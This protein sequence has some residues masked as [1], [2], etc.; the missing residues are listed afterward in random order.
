MG[1]N[2]NVTNKRLRSGYTTGTCAAAVAKACV[3]M[4]LSK[5]KQHEILV[6]TPQGQIFTLPLYEVDLGLDCA[7][8]AVRKD[9]GDDPDV[10][11]GILIYATVRNATHHEIKIDGGIGIGR[12]TKPG[13]ACSIG[14]AAINPVPRKMIVLEVEKVRE[15]YSSLQGFDI[16]IWAPKGEE[17]ASRTFNPRLGII[18][19]ISILGT[20]GI[21]EPKSLQAL[22]DTIYLEMK[23]QRALGSKNLLLCSGNYG[24]TF[25]RD[26][27]RLDQEQAVLCSNFIGEALDFSV[28]LEF[29][30]ILLVGHAG[31]LLKLGA[32][33]MNTHSKFADAR[34]EILASY[35]ALHGEPTEI[36]RM[37]MNSNTTEEAVD[38]LRKRSNYNDIF[39]SIM[40]K[41]DYRVQKRVHD[42]LKIGVIVF[43]NSIGV[44]GKTK[45]ADEIMVWHQNNKVGGGQHR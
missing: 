37:I 16:E 7:T 12:V 34:M 31:K 20:T 36:V 4:L 21:V 1:Q 45:D 18:G 26:R 38:I 19:G 28:E 8:C 2:R 10:S 42:Q 27:L 33:I 6:E 15:S 14:E 9:S 43:A 17:I 23:Q 13:L 5:K 40:E 32:G 39:Q 25:I 30:S 11:N 22:I 35:A 24:K 41:I 29:E 3:S 44:L